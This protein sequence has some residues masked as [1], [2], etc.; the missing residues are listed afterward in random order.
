MYFDVKNWILFRFH[1]NYNIFF[2]KFK[3]LSQQYVDFFRIVEKINRLFYCL[4]ISEYWMIH[5]IFIVVQ[6]KSISSP[7]INF[8]HRHRIILSN[9]IYVENNIAQIKNYEL[10]KIINSR[11]IVKKTEYL[12]KWKECKSEQNMWRNLSK[13]RNVMN[14]IKKYHRIM[15]VVVLDCYRRWSQISSNVVISSR[16]QLSSK[17]SIKKSIT[18]LLSEFFANTKVILRKSLIVIS[19]VALVLIF[20]STI[21]RESFIAMIAVSQKSFSLFLSKIFVSLRRFLRFLSLI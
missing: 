20:S 15:N 7:S 11:E 21:A 4:K 6:L 9:F 12:I 3:K 18:S 5:F 8:Y 19:I 13:M 10:K 16:N 17:T 1:R 2:A 14:M